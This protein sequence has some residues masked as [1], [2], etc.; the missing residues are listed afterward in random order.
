MRAQRVKLKSCK[1]D[2]I[3]APGKRSATRG[4][5][6]TIAPSLLSALSG[7]KDGIRLN[8]RAAERLLIKSMKALGLKMADL[9]VLPLGCPEKV[10]L[11]WWLRKHMT[12]S[13]RWVADRLIMGHYTRVTQAVSRVGRKPAKHLAQLCRQV[14]HA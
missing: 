6:H 11:A 13:L 4:N 1:D 2:E 14:E 9:K 8:E 12:V 7:L 3:I 10:V 5:R